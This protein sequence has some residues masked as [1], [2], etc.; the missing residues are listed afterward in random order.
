M[1]CIK[2]NEFKNDKK[3]YYSKA[4]FHTINNNNKQLVRME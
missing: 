2:N 1:N 4:N 3:D